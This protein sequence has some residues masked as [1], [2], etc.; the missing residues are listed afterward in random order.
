MSKA[1]EDS[2]KR[3]PV[4]VEGQPEASTDPLSQS[5]KPA[6]IQPAK[7][8]TRH[9]K[10]PHIYSCQSIKTCQ[11]PLVGKKSTLKCLISGYPVTVLFDS[12][13][14]VSIV[15]RQWAKKYITNHPV[16]PLR[17]L[18][19]DELEVY[20]VNGQTVPYDGWVEL[21]VTLAGHED[22]NLTVKAPFL[23]SQLPL[24]QPLV[25][26]NVLGVIIQRQQS[27]RD[28]N[29]VLYSLL[30]RAFEVDEEQVAAIVNFIQVPQ[31][32]D[33]TPAT[34]RVGKDNVI[35]PAG[36]AVQVWCRVPPNF[37]ITDPFVLYEPLEDNVALRHLSIGEGLLGVNMTQRPYVKIPISNHSKDDVLL[38]KRTVLGTIQ[39]VA[40]LIE[41]ETLETTS[42][43]STPITI[44]ATGVDKTTPPCDSPTDSW[45]PPVNLTHLS[46]DQQKS[47]EKVLVEECRAFSRDSGD[48][49]CIPSLQ[50]EI[51]LKDDTPVQRAYASIPKPLYREVKEYIQELLVKGWVVK[52]QSPYAAPVIC[53][54]KRD[55]TLRLCIDYRL[56]NNKTVPDKHPLPRIQDLTD[57]LGGYSWFSILDQGKAYHQGFIAEGS[58]Y[59]TAFTTPWGLYEWVRIPFG[60][61]NAP[62][63]FQRSMEEM[64]DTLRDECCIPYLDDVLCFSKSFDEHV[65]VLQKVLKALQ[66]HGVKLKPEKCELFRKEVW[67]VGRLVSAE[68]V[69]VDPK[70]IEAVQALKHRTPQ[71]V[72]DVR[73]LLGFLS[74]YR[75][76]VQDFSRIAKPLYDLLQV[77]TDISHTKPAKGKTKHPQQSSRAPIHWEREH[78]DTLER[79]IDMLTQPPVLAYPDFTCPFILHTDASQKGL[80][81]VL[82]QNQ[83]NKMRV[84]GYG[85]R[86]LTPAEQNYHL[87]SGKLEFL[88]LK[89]AVCD[90]F[91]D[92]LFYA[93]HFTIFTDNNPLTCFK[94][95]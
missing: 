74:Y 46:P 67:Y 5:V 48:I 38:P 70:D 20:A 28:A 11:V 88:A 78:Q 62:A 94:H 71:T 26:A 22:P 42:S 33:C 65:Q 41:T 45:L 52:S 15:D 24:P 66:R 39:H 69:K 91:K 10:E 47:V 17:E 57:S 34:V 44:S 32:T 56:L 61:S 14:Q 68:G 35:I 76:Y 72:G 25:G 87:H 82:Y 23:V 40:K 37:G 54:R 79:L 43:Q 83:D 12:G 93:P 49:G 50:M 64:L 86:T 27:D 9:Q 31:Q 30:R 2:G 77:K 55:G 85:S 8:C 6:P 16:R 92:Y 90:K 60:L 13:S 81:A 21:T 18:M 29:A 19:D 84:I 36:K 3:E 63:A 51:R 1:D 75:T 95:S 89:W 7:Q 58:R 73:Q 4:S 53:V 59:L 80:G